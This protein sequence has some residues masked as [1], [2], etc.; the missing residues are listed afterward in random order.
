MSAITRPVQGVREPLLTP[1][2]SNIFAIL[3]LPLL[4]AIGLLGNLLV[5]MAI[6]FDRRLH[7]VTN[8]FLFSLALADLL[9]CS[10]VMPMSLIVEVRHGMCSISN[11][12]AQLTEIQRTEDLS[13][14]VYGGEKHPTPKMI[15]QCQCFIPGLYRPIA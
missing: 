11:C 4:C 3:L 13:T 12:N 10:L 14:E 5:C 15:L 8:Y 1:D 6:W 2:V 9:V 7:N